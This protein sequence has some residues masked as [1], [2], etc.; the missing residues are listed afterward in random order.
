LHAGGSNIAL[1]SDATR[2]WIDVGLIGRV[3]WAPVQPVFI[4]LEGGLAFP[5]TRDRFHFAVPDVTAHQA[6]AMGAMCAIDA[7]VRF[8]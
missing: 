4:G 2:L 5:L 7:G 8:R 1:P 6:P 3:R